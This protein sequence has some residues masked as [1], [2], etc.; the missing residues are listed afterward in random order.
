[1][2]QDGR[3]ASNF[4]NCEL[5]KKNPKNACTQQNNCENAAFR[6]PVASSLVLVLEKGT[7]L[8]AHL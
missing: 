4:V 7:P 5:V 2:V 6:V 1:M 3:M 8:R